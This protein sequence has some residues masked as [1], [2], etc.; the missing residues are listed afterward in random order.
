MRGEKLRRE[1]ERKVRG[2]ML[3]MRG[4]KTWE[5]E[6]KGEKLGR[7]KESEVKA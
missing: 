2:E 6:V 4:E 3:A 1:K 5:R 7:E